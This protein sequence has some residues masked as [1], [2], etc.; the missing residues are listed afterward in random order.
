[1]VQT[2]TRGSAVAVALLGALMLSPARAQDAQRDVPQDDGT[3][4]VVQRCPT[5]KAKL[6]RAFSRRPDFASIGDAANERIAECQ[7]YR[8]LATAVGDGYA[9]FQQCRDAGADEAAG[10]AAKKAELRSILSRI[11]QAAVR[12]CDD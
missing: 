12:T 8:E 2:M 11:R 5:V 6:D 10:I 9:A 7:Y 1:M 4:L 3:R